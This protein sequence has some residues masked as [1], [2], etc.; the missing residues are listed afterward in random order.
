MHDR[1]DIEGE[2][3]GKD[4]GADVGAD[5]VVAPPVPPCGK[6]RATL[7]FTLLIFRALFDSA[8]PTGKFS[9]PRK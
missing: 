1:V 8:V 7:D 5:V 2:C 3:D 4:V 6:Y 9:S